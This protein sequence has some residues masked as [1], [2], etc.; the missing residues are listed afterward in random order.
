MRSSKSSSSA[1]EAAAVRIRDRRRLSRLG[2]V[3]VTLALLSALATLLIFADYTPISPTSNVV[4]GL[5]ALNACIILFLMGLLLV[6]FRRLLAARRAQTAGAG[7]HI[8]MVGLFAGIAAFPALL[9]AMVGSITLDRVLNPAFLQ[10]VRG[11]IYTTGEVARIFREAQCR[12]LLQEA[13]LT[14]MDL[15]RVS[16]LFTSNPPLFKEYFAGRAQVLGF[17]SAVMMK[18]NGVV[19]EYGTATSSRIVQ[20]EASDF[21]DARKDEPLCL[22][23][24]EGRTFVA[25]REMKSFP[26]TFMYAARPVDPLAT[27]FPVQVRN[28][29]ALYNAYEGHRRNIQIAFAT[30]YALIALIMLFSAT[31]LG[32][33]VANRLVTPIRRLITATDQVSS[34]NLYVQVPVQKSDGDL[35][36]LGETFNKM[37]SELRLQQNRL[38]AASKL[39]DERRAFTEAVL[40]GVPSAFSIHQPSSCSTRRLTSIRNRLWAGLSPRLF[41]SL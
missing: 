6:E 27:A 25:V 41:P 10:D 33:S 36:H 35:G 1:V 31:W 4:L 37:T 7:I 26:D 2:P 32:L 19:I 5:F 39:N 17:S 28:L 11:F 16:P 15:D 30:M 14:A 24:D 22:I 21:E 12:A 18:A 29:T 3:S 20:P 23:L 40:A 8:R 34:G 38:L 13:R 9:M